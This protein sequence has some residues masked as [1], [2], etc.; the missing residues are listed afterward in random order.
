[1]TDD[2]QQ[3]QQWLESA[4][5]SGSLRSAVLSGPV[6]TEA[7]T[8]RTAVSIQRVD[9]R[10]VSV[11]GR[12]MYQF[13]SNSKTQ[14]FHSNHEPLAALTELVRL[15]G[16][17]FRHLHAASV[18]SRLEARFSKRGRCFVKLLRTAADAEGTGDS[19]SAAK[20]A[21]AGNRRSRISN[22]GS[23]SIQL[24]GAASSGGF[25]HDR[26]LVSLIPEGQPCGFLIETGVMTPEGRVRA[27]HRRKF[28]Q[29]NR[30]LEFVRDILPALP[31]DRPLRV[32]DF[33]CGKSYLTFALQHYLTEVL[34]CEARICGLDQRADVVATCRRIAEQLRLSHLSFEQGTIA[35]FEVDEPPDLVVSLHACD[36]A[37]DDALAQAVRWGSPAILAVPCCQHEL[38][39]KL[40]ASALA[41]LTAYGITRE[42]FAA[43]ATDTLR[44]ALMTAAG[45]QSDVIEFIDTEHTPKNLLVRCVRSASR[46]VSAAAR[47][48]AWKSVQELAAHL[49]TPPLTLQRHLEATGLLPPNEA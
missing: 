31:A 14:Q 37:T 2:R 13:T 20:G 6:A 45:W 34:H 40:A 22:L 43:L 33:G 26:T 16:T 48:K 30:Y 15:A 24:P 23:A 32:V 5:T 38:L 39:P 12:L 44:A 1:M 41:P 4:V 8:G 21:G 9:V 19:V 46:P 27:E 25:A 47:L 3:L 29:I 42:R 35:G 17:E 28:R 36:T 10:P 49:H 18:D 11:G 7:V